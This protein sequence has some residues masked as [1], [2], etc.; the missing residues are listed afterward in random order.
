MFCVVLL[1]FADCMRFWKIRKQ[2]VRL[3][4]REREL[5]KR[6]TALVIVVEQ[7]AGGNMCISRCM[8]AGDSGWSAGKTG[9]CK[10]SSTPAIEKT[11]SLSRLYASVHL[12]PKAKP[13]RST[14]E[15][16]HS[17]YTCNL[18]SGRAYQ[19]LLSNSKPFSFFQSTMNLLK[20]QVQVR[21]PGRRVAGTPRTLK[22]RRRL[23][24]AEMQRSNSVF[25]RKPS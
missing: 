3:D 21:A 10:C 1:A 7:A 18:A 11:L 13:V 8:I 17:R 16:T 19:R 23:D 24:S 14:C 6:E 9:R 2:S 4:W 5:K 15:T 12:H 25:L 22:S 20:Y